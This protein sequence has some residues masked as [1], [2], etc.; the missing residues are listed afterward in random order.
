MS[1]KGGEVDAA[2]LA[3]R[4]AA[5]PPTLSAS[6]ASPAAALDAA[7]RGWRE[8]CVRR[9]TRCHGNHLRRDLP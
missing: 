4:L 1:R 5:G 3:A 6:S 9:A 8:N 2:G 7:C